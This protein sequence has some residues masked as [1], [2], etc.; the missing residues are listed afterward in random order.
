MVL[1]G[2]AARHAA[3]GLRRC[4][5]CGG[6]APR[7]AGVTRIEIE[8]L[9]DGVM[10]VDIAVPVG[11]HDAHGAG[12][13]AD[14]ARGGRG[15]HRRPARA[16]RAGPGAPDDGLELPQ[17]PRGPRAGCSARTTAVGARSTA[18]AGRRRRRRARDR[19]GGELAAAGV[20]QR[21]GRSDAR[22]PDA[23]QLPGPLRAERVAGQPGPP[24][25]AN[26]SAARPAR[27]GS[28]P[29]G[30][31]RSATRCAGRGAAARRPRR[32]A[33]RLEG[34]VGGR[35]AAELRSERPQFESPGRACGMARACR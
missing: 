20:V 27:G 6:S 12:E 21:R 25:S 29:T 34:R 33:G 31:S 8:R 16:R 35:L 18:S 14:R 10:P 32:R 24:G 23:L 1:R 30:T 7:T 11:R 13:R 22:L 28:G 9:G 4:G 3:G 15:P 17:Q 19:A 26:D 5:T 2:V